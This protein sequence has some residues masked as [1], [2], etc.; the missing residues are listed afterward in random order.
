MKAKAQTVCLI[1]FQ[2]I[3]SKVNVIS[4]SKVKW[5]L[6]I[7]SLFNS[8]EEGWGRGTSSVF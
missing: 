6:Q 1:F 8:L 5:Q 4:D 7:V 2:A 3:N